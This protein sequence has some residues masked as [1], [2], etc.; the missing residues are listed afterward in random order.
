MAFNPFD[1]IDL[2]G[3]SVNP[4]HYLP[5]PSLN[6]L[7][8]T[9]YL[10]PFKYLRDELKD[11]YNN[12]AEKIVNSVQH[13]PRISSR[14]LL[15]SIYSNEL[16]LVIAL[17]SI[18]AL[19]VY[20]MVMFLLKRP[21][22]LIQALIIVLALPVLGPSFFYLCDW[23]IGAGD[24]L[25]DAAAH[26]YTPQGHLEISFTLPGIVNVIGAIF[27]YW[28]VAASGAILIAI[29]YLYALM[30]I[31]IKFVGLIAIA[32]YALG[33]R[34]QKLASIM[35]AAGITVFLLG[36]PAM[37]LSMKL[38]Q[39]ALDEAPGGDNSFG[40]G[41]Y[42]LV[43]IWVA[44]LAQPAIFYISYIELRKI[45][46]KIQASVTGNVHTSSDPMDTT[47]QALNGNSVVPI[48]VAVVDKAGTAS[49]SEVAALERSSAAA[50]R[51]LRSQ[52]PTDGGGKPPESD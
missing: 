32:I 29:G 26:I 20:V 22:S 11:L 50:I 27:G 42:L 48:P 40:A 18:V 8:Y 34:S 15:D 12:A 51:D 46:G 24:E 9:D 10:N 17:S 44:I 45:F 5:G 23:V 3:P 37:V 43:A 2:P 28:L 47:D 36:R 21:L 49:S 19:L 39:L 52:I 35:L 13:P 25:S 38:G 33:P 6:P 30:A 1:L 16:G 14:E 31:A 4:T 7:N 41:L